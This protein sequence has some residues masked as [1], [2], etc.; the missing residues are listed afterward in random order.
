[1]VFSKYGM[2]ALLSGTLIF[3]YVLKGGE[4]HQSA[5]ENSVTSR[6][7]QTRQ[8][9][10]HREMKRGGNSKKMRKKKS[11]TWKSLSLPTGPEFAHFQ[12]ATIRYMSTQ[13]ISHTM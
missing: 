4:K 11:T 9:I 2:K 13:Y 8:E 12:F 1:M 6:F 3:A 7:M 5:F 10:D